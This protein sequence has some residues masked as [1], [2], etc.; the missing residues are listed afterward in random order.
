VIG[1]IVLAL[2]KRL[3]V[4]GGAIGAQ[5]GVVILNIF[6]ISTDDLAL[7]LLIVGGLAIAG[8]AFAGVA[9]GIVDIVLMVLG[10]VGGAAIARGFLDL[11]NADQGA[12]SWIIVLVGGVVGLMLIRRFKDWG[13]A[14]LAGL[15]GALLVVRGLSVWFPSLDGTLKTILVLVL[16]GAGIAFQGG[17]L[18]RSQAEAKSQSAAAPA[19]APTPTAQSASPTMSTPPVQSTPPPTQVAD[20]GPLPPISDNPSTPMN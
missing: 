5:V 20:T 12:L 13:M 8:F 4:L 16:A 7:M 6:N 2:G 14:I 19:P 1:L 15:V 10:A 9:S 18:N 3:A 11:F 17:L